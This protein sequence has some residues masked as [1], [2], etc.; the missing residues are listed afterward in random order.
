MHDATLDPTDPDARRND[1]PAGIRTVPVLPLTTGVVLPQM[2]VTVALET[3]DA[4]AAVEQV[5]SSYGVTSVVEP[6][7]FVDTR[8]ELLDGSEAVESVA[9]EN[10]SIRIWVAPATLA[11]FG[12][13]GL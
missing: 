1:D 11:T 8:S 9:R 2:V 10:F 3:P 7:G 12:L 6:G 5:A 4:R 13:M